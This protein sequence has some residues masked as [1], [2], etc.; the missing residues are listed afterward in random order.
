MGKRLLFGIVIG[1][2][3][4]A[5]LP[6]NV[7]A[8][9][10]ASARVRIGYFAF[11]PRTVETYIDGEPAPFGAGWAKTPWNASVIP[12]FPYMLTNAATPFIW[13]PAGAHTFTFVPQG[14]SVDTAI[15]GP[16]EITFEAG[17]VY[18]LAIVGHLDAN[19]L[20]VLVIDETNAFSE[21]DPNKDFMGIVVHNIDGVPSLDFHSRD[22]VEA[23]EY[24]QF[25]AS[26]SFAG[27]PKMR[28]TP[29]EA[30]DTILFDFTAISAP[31]ISDL[32]CLS[33][34]Y[35]GNVGEDYFWSWNW[36]YP[37]EITIMDGGTVAVGDEIAGEIAEVA[38]RV[39]YTL[40]VDAD[41]TLNIYV[42]ATGLRKYGSW[43]SG[44]FDPQLYIYDAQGNLLFWNDELS[45]ADDSSATPEAYDAGLE[46][47]A[48]NAGNYFVEAAG[49][50][51]IVAG[52]Y[53]LVVESVAI[54]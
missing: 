20:K 49:S 2:L 32:S 28:V 50:V 53:M 38:Q 48:L 35:P 42:N 41:T 54:E 19:D 31:G 27:Y 4:I 33:G 36:G 44:R 26:A 6:V 11:D 21:A 16:Q 10:D 12:D 22:T 7:K 52:P 24:S 25:S 9:D 13:F 14:E 43:G 3:V 29:H 46:Q 5:A 8:Q 23:V 37:G 15:L 1:A 34:S 47:L 45:F 40:T 39:R 18:S 51:D 30:P 17:H